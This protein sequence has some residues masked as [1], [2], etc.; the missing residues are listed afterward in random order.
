[1]FHDIDVYIRKKDQ[2]TFNMVVG[3]ASSILGGI[4]NLM[5]EKSYDKTKDKDEI[6][7]AAYENIALDPRR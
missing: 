2:S 3:T 7:Y 4:N 1:M 6:T 5:W